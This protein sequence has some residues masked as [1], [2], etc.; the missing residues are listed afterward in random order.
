[1]KL[2][3]V[4]LFTFPFL[5]NAVEVLEV[6]GKNITFQANEYEIPLKKRVLVYSKKKTKKGKLKRLAI[7]RITSQKD[8]LYTAK[9][10]K[11]YSKEK[12]KTG[13]LVKISKKFKAKN[14]NENKKI[15]D[16]NGNEK[17]AKKGK[18]SKDSLNFLA[19]LRPLGVA[20]G[21]FDVEAEFALKGSSKSFG[22]VFAYIG[23]ESD[24]G[25]QTVEGFG[26]IGKY[27]RY[28]SPRA[29]SKGFYMSG[30]FGLFVLTANGVASNRS[31]LNVE[32]YV[33]YLGGSLGYQ[34]LFSEKFSL[35][36]GG[37]AGYYLISSEI[38]TTSLTGTA[39]TMEIPLS[40]FTPL[41]DFAIGYSF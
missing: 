15:A 36:V 34:F 37:G 39:S 30:A 16:K 31:I 14:N 27:N 22:L 19:K 29:I 8:K 10:I 35:S 5:A 7:A 40:G 38:D 33:P 21:Y 9:I 24:S 32:L 18:E 28:F 17:D 13:Y 26:V 25:T 1:M 4:L 23:L 41:V 6:K 12:I 2:L 11:R 3:L 20:T